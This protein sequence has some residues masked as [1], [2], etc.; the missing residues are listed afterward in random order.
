M[1]EPENQIGPPTRVVT[2]PHPGM[3]GFCAGTI[4]MALNDGDGRLQPERFREYLL[5]LARRH[6]GNAPRGRLDPSD[7]VQETLLEAHRKRD[8]FRGHTEGEMG[9]YLRKMLAFGLADAHRAGRRAKRDVARERSLEGELDRSSAN[10]GSVLI[11]DTSSP[12]A[13][14]E[15]HERAVHLADALALLPEDQREA[16]VLRHYENLPLADISEKMGRS[17]AAV[18]GLLKR[19]SKRLRELLKD[20]EAH[21]GG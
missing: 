13:K 2:S 19:G 12:S 9:A 5:L 15:R 7:V 20:Q 16:V 14:V 18:A 10:L 17:P 6:L 11:A 21:D 1:M 3:R 4:S 8:Q